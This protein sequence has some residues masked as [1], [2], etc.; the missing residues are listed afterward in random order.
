MPKIPNPKYDYN[1][2]KLVAAYQKAIASIYATLDR[3]DISN[4]TRANT[5]AMLTEVSAVLASLNEEAAAW[6]AENIP[7]AARD[8]VL[9]SLIALDV[10]DATKVAAFNKLNREMV[11][12]VVADT[13]SDLLAVTQNIDRRVRT[14]VRQVT[15]ESMRANMTRG[16]NGRKTISRDILDGLK[17]KLGDS[18]NTGIIDSAGRRWRPEI[19]TDMIVRTKTMQAHK[20]ASINEAIGRGALY[21]V[22]SRHGA[23]DACRHWEGKIVKLVVDAPGDY[24]YIGD[25]PRNEIF[26]P[27]CKHVVTPLRAPKLL[28]TDSK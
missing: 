17:K 16:I 13:Q 26:H 12:A 11:A 20:E 22:I 3:I 27:C 9:S 18:V 1:T 8:G 24:P 5:A 21:G 6:V 4:M 23:T 19:Y 15:A 10:N 14:V 25:I 7:L 28:E 2:D